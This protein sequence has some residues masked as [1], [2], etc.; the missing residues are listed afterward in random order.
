MANT[1]MTLIVIVTWTINSSWIG[2]KKPIVTKVYFQ[3]RQSVMAMIC[4]HIRWACR[5]SGCISCPTYPSLA[6]LVLS[7]QLFRSLI[8]LPAITAITCCCYVG[9][10]PGETTYTQP[11]SKDTSGHH[12]GLGLVSSSHA[13]EGSSSLEKPGMQ[14]ASGQA[15]RTISISIDDIYD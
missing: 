2:T 15:S 12:H 14:T 13:V 11:T 1:Q 9:V 7:D 6:T 5:L 4:P 8:Y 3:R 10:H